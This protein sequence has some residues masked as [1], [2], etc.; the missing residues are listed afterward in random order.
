MSGTRWT[1]PGQGAEIGDLHDAVCGA[2]RWDRPSTDE[3]H[4]ALKYLI[5]VLNM[6]KRPHYRTNLALTGEPLQASD[7]ENISKCK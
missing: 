6:P 7:L 1:E 4:A 3:E 2:S 5:D